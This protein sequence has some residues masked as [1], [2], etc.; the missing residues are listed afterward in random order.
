MAY[1]PF[2][3]KRPILPTGNWS[4]ALDDFDWDFL[5]AT[6]PR[7]PFPPLP[8]PTADFAAVDIVLVKYF[9]Y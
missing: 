3:R 6:L 5:P 1:L 2:F 9:C 4:P 7:P 8:A